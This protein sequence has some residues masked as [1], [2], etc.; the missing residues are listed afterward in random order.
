VFRRITRDG[1]NDFVT[2]SFLLPALVALIPLLM[3]PGLLFH[4]DSLP[5]VA[6]LVLAM[7]IA[8][9]RPGRVARDLEELWRSKTGKCLCLLAAVQVIW[10]AVATAASS[11]VLFSV[12][13]SN[14]RRLGLITIAALAVFV[15]LA[16]AHLV[17]Q[18]RHATVVLRAMTIVAIGVSLYAVAQYFNID[19]LQDSAGYHAQDGDFTIVRPPGTLGHADYLGWWLAIAVFCC[20]GLSRFDRPVW[21]RLALAAAFLSAI[22]TVL[23]G[24]RSAIAAIGLGVLFLAISAPTRPRAKHL[25]SAAA[26]T[27][28]LVV[29]YQSPAGERLRARVRWSSDEV[30]GGGRPLLWRDA[31]KMAAS[32]PLLGFG[33]ETFPAEFPKYQSVDLARLVPDFYHESPHN[34]ALDALTSEGVPGLFIAMGW[35]AIGLYAIADGRKRNSPVYRALAAAFVASCAASVFNAMTIG[36]AVSTLTVIALLIARNAES[37]RDGNVT[38][39][40]ASRVPATFAMAIGAPAAVVFAAFGVMLLVS[41]FKLERFSRVAAKS[42]AGLTVAAYNKLRR[43]NFTGPAEDLYCSRRLASV[44]GKGGDPVAR[45]ECSQ[46][47]TQAAAHATITADNPP[48]A[49]YNLAMFA[50]AHNDGKGTEKALRT[51]T[52][53]APNWFRPHWALANFLTLSGRKSEAVVEIDRASLLGAGKSPQVSD[54]L[55]TIAQAN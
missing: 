45:L 5:K 54:S 41:D 52:E 35:L 50:A 6:I 25:M 31:I 30:P 46:I 44:C 34:L 16:A 20:W 23:S 11:R 28:V 27:L 37:V 19:P 10:S 13:G 8:L 9:M 47:A 51:A 55:R 12:F 53:L 33:P 43:S 49:W 4:Y 14:W 29:F 32:H 22:A 48:N 7:S 38:A 2:M 21:R 18:P 3:T 26:I 15:V 17:S 40:S 36:P 1:P 39:T 24:T 42:D